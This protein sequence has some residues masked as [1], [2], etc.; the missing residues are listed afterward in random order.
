MMEEELRRLPSLVDLP[1]PEGTELTVCGDVHGQ[2]FDVLNLFD[3]NGFPSPDN[4]YLFNGDFVDRGS[5]SLEI[6]MIFFSFKLLYPNSFHMTRGNHETNNMNNIYGFKG[7]L[8]KKV[9]TSIYDAFS[10]CFNW[11]P[12]AYCIQRKVL[13]VHGGLFSQ[14]GVTLDDIR[15]ISRNCQPPDSGLMCELLW[16]D[17]Q[18]GRGRAPSKRGVGLSFGPD[19]SHRFLEENGLTH[20]IRSHEVKQNGYE[21]MHDGKVITVFSAPNYCDQ[22]GNKAAFIRINHAVNMDFTTYNAVPHPD[23]RPMAYAAPMFN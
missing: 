4:P 20:L 2:L 10:S 11:L 21:M 3:I 17:P 18:V 19:V 1:I 9:D 22:V 8:V 6:I 12:L 23:I 13:V 16:S 7:E 15:R 14:D 5:W